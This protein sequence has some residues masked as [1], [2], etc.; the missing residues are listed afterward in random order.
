V[1]RQVWHFA[2]LKA[3]SVVVHVRLVGGRFVAA[4]QV[5]ENFAVGVIKKILRHVA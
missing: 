5:C 1:Q 3:F 2:W 4:V